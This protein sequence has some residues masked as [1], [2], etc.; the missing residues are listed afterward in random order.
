AALQVG[1]E[2]NLAGGVLGPADTTVVWQVNGIPD[3]NSTVGTITPGSNNTAVYTAPAKVPNPATVSIQAVSHAEPDKM[4]VCPTT[5]SLNTPT[6]ATVTLTPVVVVDQAQHSFTFHADVI[7]DS[8]N[9]VYWTVDGDTGGSQLNGTIAS[10]GPDIGVY[11]A[12]TTVPLNYNTV[13]VKAISNGQPS[14]SAAAIMGISAPPPL[15][16]SVN[17][18]G[19]TSVEIGSSLGVTAT[20]ANAETQSVTWKV[21]GITGGNAQYGTIVPIVGN[22]NQ[23]TYYPPAQLPAQETVVVSA[24]PDADPQIA[25]VLPVTIELA[26]VQVTVTPGKVQLGITQQTQFT[27]SITNLSNQ[28]AN[29]YVGQGNTFVLGGNATLGTI[30]PSSNANVVT[31]TAPAAVP[32][33]PTVVI[34]AVSEA[35]PSAFGTATVTLSK[36]PVVTVSITPSTPQQVQVNDSVGPYSAVVT[37]DVNQDVNWYVCS[38]PN[39]CYQDGN[40]TLGMMIPSPD[41]LTKELYIAPPIVPSPSTVFVEAR[42]V[43]F[44]NAISNLDAVTVQNEQQQPQVQI[45]PQPYALLPGGNEQVYAVVTDIDDH[46]VDWSL[47]LPDGEQCTQATCGSVSP[48]ETNNAPTT[49]TAPQTIPQDPYYVSI[50]ATSKALPSVKGT[51]QIEISNNVVWSV[52]INPSQP[53]PIQAGS[54]NVITFSV[55]INNAPLD[56][57]TLWS[58]GC[59]SEAPKEFGEPINCGSPKDNGDGTGCIVSQ[60]GQQSACPFGGLSLLGE[61]QYVQYSPPP[62]L[63]NN[64]QENYCTDTPG[65]DGFIPLSATIGGQGGNCVGQSCTAIVCIEVTPSGD[66]RIV[67]PQRKKPVNWKQN[68]EKR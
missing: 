59:I 13:T 21:N 3:G 68:L 10:E 55:V 54:S 12:P 42:S 60:D 6:V 62:K 19:G 26:A 1:T 37:G 41:D 63:G 34:K 15:G 2:V 11:T 24:V 7:N 36:N 57:T 27:A 44:P 50:T 31:Y 33:N 16:V 43:D 66:T 51:A 17:V 32:A 48:I 64:F 9:S 53:P 40:A 35:V 28:N 25:G 65:P 52:S 45:D 61:N 30:S 8:D 14:R 49:Y 22:T 58:L 47:T 23:A 4:A 20:V 18:V 67:P 5:I 38:D 29:W 56:T 39:T 46:T